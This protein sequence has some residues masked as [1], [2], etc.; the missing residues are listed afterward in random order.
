MPMSNDQSGGN[1]T[2]RQ[3]ARGGWLASGVHHTGIPICV[4]GLTED[5][6][7]ERFAV[8]LSEWSR[9]MDRPDR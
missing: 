4:N 7:R 2:L 8:A 5:E 9:L 3:R 1:P 6:A